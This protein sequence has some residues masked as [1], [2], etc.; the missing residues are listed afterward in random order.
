MS[1][2][3][4]ATLSAL[5]VLENP[6]KAS[7][8]M[9]VFTCHL[10]VGPLDLEKIQGSV[11]YYLEE[12][13]EYPDAGVYHATIA[14]AKME[15]SVNVSTEDAKEQAEVSFVRD[16]KSFFLIRGLDS[17]AVA[18]I[19]L[20]RCAYVNVCGAVTRSDSNAA[21]FTFDAEQYTAPSLNSKIFCLL[22]P[23]WSRRSRSSL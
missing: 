10:F 12:D 13:G 22:A 9:T 11:W 20:G 3:S 4:Y 19:D 23:L 16:I 2:S 1:P 21:T 15:K 6:R 5:T 7:P 14:V 17:P 18:N 8:R